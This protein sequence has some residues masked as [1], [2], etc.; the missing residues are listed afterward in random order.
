MYT[1]FDGYEAAGLLLY[2]RKEN[3]SCWYRSSEKLR[4]LVCAEVAEECGKFSGSEWYPSDIVSRRDNGSSARCQPRCKTGSRRRVFHDDRNKTLHLYSFANFVYFI[5][6][7]AL[8]SHKFHFLPS[9][10]I[11]EL[12]TAPVKILF[13]TLPRFSAVH[14]RYNGPGFLA[15]AGH[16]FLL[17]ANT[18]VAQR[19]DSISTRFRGAFSE[20]KNANRRRQDKCAKEPIKSTV[21]FPCVIWRIYDP[22]CVDWGFWYFDCYR[23][24]FRSP[25]SNCKCQVML[26]IFS[27]VNALLP[28]EKIWEV[29]HFL[30]LKDT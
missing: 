15:N 28:W 19:E 25:E 4:P 20:E 6:L 24:M 29:S 11:P 23:W 1:S 12:R 7:P 22:V 2:F 8:V 13:R 30:L 17:L 10:I 21:P 5:Y 18:P 16:F 27:A 14:P 9:T 26:S 3:F